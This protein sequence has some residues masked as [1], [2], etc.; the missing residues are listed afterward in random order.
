MEQSK[1]VRI[2]IAGL[3]H[4]HVHWLLGRPPRGD[5][6]IA[7]I[8]EPDHDLALHYAARYGFQPDLIFNNLAA[9]ADAVQPAAVVAFGSIYDHLSVVEACAPR[10][11]HVMVEKPL[12]VNMAHATAMAA[13]ANQYEI[14]LLTNFE[15]TWYASTSA[16]YRLVV[17]QRLIGNIRKVVVHDGHRGPQEL[18]CT[19]DFLRWLTD[20]IQNGGGALTDFGCYGANLLTWFMGG[21]LPI[22]VTAVTQQIKPHLYPHVDDEAT[23]ILTYPWA[24]GIIQASWNWPISRKDIEL[25]GE[26]GTVHALD[27]STLRIQNAGQSE[28]RLQSLAPSPAPFDDPFAYLAAV[29]RDDVTLTGTELSSLTNNMAVVQILDAA[30]E[31]AKIGATVALAHLEM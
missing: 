4:D 22:S 11:I 23:I 31:S 29:V 8:Y 2:G 19:A 15:T 7:G 20:P 3:S 30:R 17:E 6:E 13:L 27:S 1:P 18:G 21:A 28:A 24:Q 25:Y 16:V 12:A 14:H 26:T 9:M 5:I 10:G